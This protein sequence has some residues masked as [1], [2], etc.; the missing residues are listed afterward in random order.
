MLG[1]N[2]AV[3]RV[4]TA[5]EDQPNA[6]RFV[7]LSDRFWK[8]RF[9]GDPGVVNRSIRLGGNV[10]TVVGVMPPGFSILD[11]NV[12]VWVPAGFSAESR[13]PQGRW[14]MVVARLKDGVT[15]PQAQDD[16]TRVASELTRM[17]PEFRHR[18]DRSGRAAQGATDRRDPARAARPAWRGRFRA[19]DCL[20]QCRQPSAR[21]R[22]DAS[23]RAGGASGAGRGPRALDP[24][25]AR[26]KPAAG[27]RR[28]CG[29][30]RP[31]LVG[32][33]SSANGCR[34]E[35]ARSHGSSSSASTDG[36]FSLPARSALASGLLFGVIPAFA[37][38]GTSLTDAL[39]EGGRTGTASRGGR[40]RNA[41][42]VI[43]M[44]LALVLLVGAGLLVRSFMTLM[45]VDPGFRSLTYDDDEG[46]PAVRQ[47]SGSGQSIAFFDRLF[48]RLD[49]LPGVAGGGG[50]QLPSAPRSR[51]GDELFHRGTRETTS[52][53]RTGCR[54]AS[55][56]ARLLQGDGHSA[57]SRPA[58]RQS[59]HGAEHPAHHRQRI[60]GEEVLRRHGSD[61]AA[62]RACAGTTRVRTRSSASSATSGRRASRRNPRA[63]VI[64]RRLASRIRS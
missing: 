11:K 33:V 26:R 64:F 21:S 62:D 34:D 48:A 53:R 32:P 6:S 23:A 56:H 43:E 1:V 41:L 4:F 24:A 16:M 8:R 54:R 50:S 19:A 60:A 3:G 51:G 61:R 35:P 47:L 7:L 29:G 20:R 13:T 52:G 55:C 36:F 58:V 5:A 46:D 37:A 14:T 10:F 49:T 18:M 9:G 38:A 17:F 45:R 27:G 57:A 2:A 44:A 30:R 12:D 31:R 22:D 42:V 40:A 15:F 59:R 25:V 63:P 39:K 28:W